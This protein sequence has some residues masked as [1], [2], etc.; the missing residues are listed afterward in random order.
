LQ[1]NGGTAGLGHAKAAA[2][3]LLGNS[4]GLVG[5]TPM[6][7]GPGLGA[8]SGNGEGIPGGNSRRG[9]SG[10]VGVRAGA[11]SG[12]AGFRCGSSGST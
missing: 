11:G 7:S 6:G 9:L 1:K 4:G 5:G 12:F 10:G 8:C 3:A 2:R